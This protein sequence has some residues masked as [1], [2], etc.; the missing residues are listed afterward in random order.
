M[1]TFREFIREVYPGF[2]F[3]PHLDKLI[4]LLQR[5]VDGQLKRLMVF[6]P[7]RH[8]K[9]EL[10]SRLFS[11]YYLYRHPDQ[12]I[13]I[14]SYAAELAYTF[15]RN[16]RD[17]YQRA[18]GKLRE[19]AFAVRHWETGQ[20]GGLWAA[21]VGGPITGK[22]WH[23]GII[24]D[25]LK[26]AEEAASEIIR[27]KHKDW[28]RS[29]FSTREEPNGAL[30]I[31]LTRWHEDDLAGWLLAQE[32]SED[33]DAEQWH[34]LSLPALAEASPTD[35]PATCTVEQDTRQPDEAL[36]P[37][38]YSATKLRRIRRRVG[39]YFWAALYQQRPAPK[40]GDVFRREW[41]DIVRA[42]PIGCSFV[43][44]WDKAASHGKGAYTA[45]VLFARSP[46]G[47]YFVADVVRGQWSS[48][49]REAIIEQTAHFD[50]Q[51]YGHVDIWIEQ[52]PGSGGKESAENTIRNL[53]GYAVKAEPVTGDKETRARP[54][55]AQAEVGNV[56][57]LAGRWN[58][59]FLDELTAFPTG[60][61]KDQVDAASGAFNKLAHR[62]P[63]TVQSNAIT[64][65]EMME[66]LG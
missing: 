30:V 1:L 17:N 43:R 63:T 56:A 54:L 11:A 65:T 8:G 50:Q 3:Y 58:A 38:R 19:D 34:I 27:E 39:E 12:W 51:R 18:G 25:P 35:F 16:A 22:G 31:V 29:V 23:L 37:E 2:R 52:E 20:G 36:C 13:G 44:Y 53:E 46:D 64:R 9:S 21:G 15:S 33:E 48:G 26:N 32:E 45:G 60:R 28:Y 7:P 62:K 55:A 40:G 59:A 49:Q 66:L 24:D 61:Y 41:F 4:T 57:L 10:V 42:L 6:M 14:N 5:V 47:R